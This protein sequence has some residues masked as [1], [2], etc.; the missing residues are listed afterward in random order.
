MT[1]P[2]ELDILTT[3]DMLDELVAWWEVARDDDIPSPDHV[4]IY[5]LFEGADPDIL[6]HT[7]R[8][9][10]DPMY[11]AAAAAALGA[12]QITEA[13]PDLVQARYDPDEDVRNFA[14]WAVYMLD[15]WAGCYDLW[16]FL[17][18]AARLEMAIGK[19]RQLRMF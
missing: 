8:D 4:E 19:P 18:Q 2:I 17:I 11:R 13:L 14:H 7:L 5:R 1:D 16:D 9:A 10:V 15:D 3:Q 6:R 12:L